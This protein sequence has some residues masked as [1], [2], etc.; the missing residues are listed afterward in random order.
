MH[1]DQHSDRCALLSRGHDDERMAV[2]CGGCGERM[3]VR[4][5]ELLRVR[6]MNCTLCDARF[7]EGSDSFDAGDH[8][9]THR[10]TSIQM[11]RVP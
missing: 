10:G 7:R 2:N 3:V 11:I 9:V 4:L 5:S 6:T 8:V 1:D